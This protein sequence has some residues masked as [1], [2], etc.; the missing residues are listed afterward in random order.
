MDF[1]EKVKPI[2]KF[3]I[4]DQVIEEITEMI[5]KGYLKPGDNLPGERVLSEKLGISRTSLRQAL[6]ALNVIGVLEISTG[7]KTFIKNSF[8]DI[9]TNPFR[10]IKAIH[11]IKLKEVFEARR[12][13]EEGLA[14]KAAMKA[15]DNDIKRLKSYIDEAEKNLENKSEFI[16]SEFKFHQYIFNIADNKILDAV[17]NSLNDLLLVLEKYEKDYL[18]LE[19][20][21]ISL[22]QHKK[23]YDAISMRNADKA[24]L[25]MHNHLD[26]MELRLQKM[27]KS[28]KG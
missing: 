20:R 2:E 19:D 14:Q 8:S 1:L 11:S 5:E 6:K 16:Y 7:K 24:R 15:E 27:E 10:F 3:I 9:L 26:T 12:I 21:K 28:G 25:A 17:M 23:I 13:L 22:D 18:T 4:I